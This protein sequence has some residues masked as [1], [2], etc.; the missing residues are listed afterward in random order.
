MVIWRFSLRSEYD[1]KVRRKYVG[2][3]WDEFSNYLISESETGITMPR[4]I[5]HVIVTI[6]FKSCSLD[7]R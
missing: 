6:V 4:Q 2:T 1:S 5:F 3:T 7:K